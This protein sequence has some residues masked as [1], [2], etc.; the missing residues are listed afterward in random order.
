MSEDYLAVLAEK[1]KEKYLANSESQL[2][3]RLEALN[4]K[5]RQKGL[6]AFWMRPEPWSRHWRRL[7]AS[8]A[9]TRIPLRDLTGVGN[10]TQT[11][12]VAE[13]L[14]FVLERMAC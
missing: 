1:K 2:D 10:R 7:G 13:R 5:I 11:Q 9:A 14:P 4:Q 6:F 3:G 12:T 8:F